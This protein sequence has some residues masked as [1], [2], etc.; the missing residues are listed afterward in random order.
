MIWTDVLPS[1]FNKI[2]YNIQFSFILYSVNCFIIYVLAQQPQGNWTETA[3][4]HEEN[5]QISNNKR[6][7]NEK[8]NKNE[9]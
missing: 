6:K 4:E 1:A 7:H 3:R 2:I 8:G 9:T 5:T